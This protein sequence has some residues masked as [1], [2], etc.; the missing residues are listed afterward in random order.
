MG[1][2]RHFQLDCDKQ[3]K[4]AEVV[5]IWTVITNWLVKPPASG[6]CLETL[7]PYRATWE[8]LKEGANFSEKTC[9]WTRKCGGQTLKIY[10]QKNI[11][12]PTSKIENKQG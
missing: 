2:Y 4:L 5:K 11:Y 1:V 10:K 3:I 9:R 8:D 6:K 7:I 12:T